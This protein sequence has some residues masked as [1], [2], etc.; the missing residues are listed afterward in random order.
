M[1]K[2][3]IK[4]FAYHVSTS[5]DMYHGVTILKII[6]FD[7][8]KQKYVCLDYDLYL[9]EPNAIYLIK[10]EELEL[11]NGSKY[12]KHIPKDFILK[13][14]EK[15]FT[16]EMMYEYPVYDVDGTKFKLVR[17]TIHKSI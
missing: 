5:G 11:L 16:K 10:D 3:K 17:N 6:S 15:E 1:K 14:Q 2:F 7:D 4:D 12:E 13:E 8:L 9:L